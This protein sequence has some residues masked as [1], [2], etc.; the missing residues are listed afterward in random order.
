MVQPAELCSLHLACYRQW[1]DQA[2]AST[3]SSTVRAL[4]REVGDELKILA[5]H[6]TEAIEEL[7]EALIGAFESIV[8]AMEIE[9]VTATSN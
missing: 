4:I 3:A 6:G 9:S 7:Q 8:A 2:H 1:L 5:T